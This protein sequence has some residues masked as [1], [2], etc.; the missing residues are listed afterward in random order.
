MDQFK[1]PR[2]FRTYFWIQNKAKVS[3]GTIG[4]KEI[5]QTTKTKDVFSP[6]TFMWSKH[7]C[8]ACLELF[9]KTTWYGT[10]NAYLNQKVSYLKPKWKPDRNI[11]TRIWRGAAD[12][13]LLTAVH[14]WSK[15]LLLCGQGMGT[16]FVD[17]DFGRASD[18]V[19]HSLAI[20]KLMAYEVDK[21]MIK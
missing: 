12:M 21:R 2:R 3:N 13:D 17:P 18:A 6:K 8:I 14:S 20:I 10:G 5:K 15:S 16:E 11:R 1:F 19:S 4:L 9:C 7:L